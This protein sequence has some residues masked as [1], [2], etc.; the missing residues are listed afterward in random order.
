MARKPENDSNPKIDPNAPVSKSPVKW[1]FLA[2]VGFAVILLAPEW[3]RQ[4]ISMTATPTIP[5]LSPLAQKGR[6]LIN[7]QCKE[8]HGVDGTGGTRK[9][10]PLLHP[11][12]RAAVYPDA[13][14]KKAL[15]EGARERIWRFG[16]MPAQPQLSDTDVNAIISFVRSVQIASGVK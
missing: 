10:P 1:M 16:P 11:T 9:G 3:S 8:C 7:A 6:T 15:K 5:E 4:K 12:Y 14:F 2:L 13:E